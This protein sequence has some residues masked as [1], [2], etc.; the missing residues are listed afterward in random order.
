MMELAS[1]C[2]DVLLCD[3][4][5]YILLCYNYVPRE[6]GRHRPLLLVKPKTFYLHK[7]TMN[8]HIH[9]VNAYT[10]NALVV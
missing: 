3:T 7:H 9:D 10:M 4:H 1:Y 6:Q 2:D 5:S 8:E